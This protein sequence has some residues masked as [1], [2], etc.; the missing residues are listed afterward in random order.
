MHYCITQWTACPDWVDLWDTID[1]L[2]KPRRNRVADF[3]V[4]GHCG[5]DTSKMKS[6]GGTDIETLLGYEERILNPYADEKNA[7]NNRLLQLRRKPT[8]NVSRQA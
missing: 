1:K 4:F 3:G 8:G 6:L 2:H 5:E 7:F